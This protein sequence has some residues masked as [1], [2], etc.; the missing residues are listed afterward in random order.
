MVDS[1]AIKS[2][3]HS[4]L[5]VAHEVFQEA[6][7]VLVYDKWEALDGK[8][9]AAYCG[10]NKILALSLVTKLRCKL[11]F[12]SVVLLDSILMPTNAHVK[13]RMLKLVNGD[14]SIEFTCKFGAL[15]AELDFDSETT[16]GV[17]YWPKFAGSSSCKGGFIF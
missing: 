16:K 12:A 9:L 15:Y 3:D 8:K 2:F 14:P 5:L 6:S 17:C 11:E 13:G 10:K 1:L 7:S 4:F